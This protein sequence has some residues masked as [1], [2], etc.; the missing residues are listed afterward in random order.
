VGA[1]VCLFYLYVFITIHLSVYVHFDVSIVQTSN[2]NMHETKQSETRID[3]K[4]R[5]T[6]KRKSLSP[7]VVSPTFPYIPLY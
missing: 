4:R 3:K 5:K 6:S 1:N 7:A 2:L